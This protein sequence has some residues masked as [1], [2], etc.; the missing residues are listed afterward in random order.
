[1]EI[2]TSQGA[3]LGGKFAAISLAPMVNFPT[4]IAGVNDTV[5]DT[6]CNLLKHLAVNL[7]PMSTTPVANNENS[8]SLL[9]PLS[10]LE[11]KNYL[12]VN[13]TTRKVSKQ[14]N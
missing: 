10:E 11:G 7:P 14:N 2:F 4:G 8:I 1:M 12:Y 3:P 5:T 13:H 9:T 6:S